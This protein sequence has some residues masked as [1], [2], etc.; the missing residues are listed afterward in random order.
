MAVKIHCME[1]GYFIEIDGQCSTS[2]LYGFSCIFRT[3][4]GVLY[5]AHLEQE[6]EA[7]ET[8][9]LY[10]LTPT[11]S[12]TERDLSDEGVE[13]EEGDPEDDE[14]EEEEG[15]AEDGDEVE[16]E[17]EEEGDDDKPEV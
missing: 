16:V 12:L 14:E 5:G 4:N 3:S 8:P 15:E 7:S 13:Y 17:D 6:P 9:Q 11:S 1:S 2:H 10:K